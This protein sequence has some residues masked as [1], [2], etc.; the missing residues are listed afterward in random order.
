MDV[1]TPGRYVTHGTGCAPAPVHCQTPIGVVNIDPMHTQRPSGVANL[2]LQV[3]SLGASVGRV[4][5]PGL[6]GRRG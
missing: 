2:G 3:A 6:C 4:C 1:E 5:M